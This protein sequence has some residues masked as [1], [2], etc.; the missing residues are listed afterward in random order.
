MK[1]R[2]DWI[3]ATLDA[4]DVEGTRLRYGKGLEKF[5]RWYDD[6]GQPELNANTLNKFKRWLEGKNYSSKSIAVCFFSVK[7]ALSVCFRPLTID[8]RMDLIDMQAVRVR[9]I[10]GK[11]YAVRLSKA[12]VDKL[13]SVFSP[14]RILDIRNLAIV[15]LM[16]YAGLRRGS[17]AKLE[18]SDYDHERGML[19]IREAKGNK[20]Y[21]IP[22]HDV[23]IDN[24]NQWVNVRYRWANRSNSDNLFL[25]SRGKGLDGKVCYWVVKTTCK[26]AGLP[27]YH[28]HD[29]RSTFITSLHDAGVPIGDIQALVG[30][31]NPET[32]MGYVRTDWSKLKKSV[33]KLL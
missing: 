17:V 19:T 16:F 15:T 29:A 2:E 6:V 10:K 33:S 12:E 11:G 22:L 24:L 8:D 9:Q 27:H 1:F 21:A 32:T 28:P 20:S 30:H 26:R 3:Q 18:L 31:A 13:F 5:W 7:K 14:N 4:I 25:T 23:A